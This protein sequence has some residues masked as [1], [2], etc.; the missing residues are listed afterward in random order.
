M[1][2]AVAIAR[3]VGAAVTVGRSGRQDGHRAAVASK[4][5]FDEDPGL[6]QQGID[7]GADLVVG[8]TGSVPTG[9][10]PVTTSGPR[11]SPNV[12]NDMVIAREEIFGPVLCILRLR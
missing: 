11:C 1:D 4:V 10:T 9:W 5:Q 8:G 6:I 7:A 3:E 12:T 2:E